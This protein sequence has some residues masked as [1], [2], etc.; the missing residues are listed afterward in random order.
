MAKSRLSTKKRKKRRWLTIS[1]AVVFMVLLG[2]GGFIFAVWNNAKQTVNDEIHQ[3]VDTIDTSIAKQKIEDKEPLNILLLGVDERST[4]GGRSD[5]LMVLSLNPDG[6]SMQIVSIPRDTRTEIVGRGTED[7]INHA[8]AFGGVDMSINTVE[9]LLDIELDYYV[10]M[11]MEGLS[12]MVD[13]VGG[14]TVNNELDW[15]DEGFYK[16]D[17]H[18]A[19]GELELNGAQTMGFVRMR[20]LDPDGDFGRTKRQRQV[21]QAV[22]DRGASIK[23]INKIDDMIE[24]LGDNVVTNMDF[25]DMQDLV[26]N[27]R[28]TRKSVVSYM[29][30]GTGTKI[31]GVYYLVVSAEEIEK[32]HNMIKKVKS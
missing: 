21:I 23:S 17:Y 22:I 8:Y 32:V 9:N 28:D 11:N 15:Y 2:G 7:K 25:K 20:H 19:K 5:A 31:D 12:G 3:Q 16:K 24:V 14:I 30:Q 10:R 26:L 6:D 29:M 4:D 1:L 18:Y 13:A 27:Y